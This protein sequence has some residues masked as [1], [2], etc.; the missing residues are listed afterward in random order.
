M[1][2]ASAVL[3]PALAFAQEID[4]EQGHPLPGQIGLQHSVTPI[5]DSITVFHNGILLWTAVLITLLVLALLSVAPILP[6][7][8]DQ[9]DPVGHHPQYAG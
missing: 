8:L 6:V 1:V 5:M 9:P 7:E 3:A 2:T 4:P